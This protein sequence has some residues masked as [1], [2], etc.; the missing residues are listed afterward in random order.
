MPEYQVR[1]VLD[2]KA[3]HGE[4]PLWSVEEQ[5]LF[6]VDIQNK[7]F[8][9]FDPKSGSNRAWTLPATPGCFTFRVGGG[10]VIAANRGYYDFDFATSAI[11]RI[12]AAPFDPEKFRFNDGKADRN[13][14]FWAGS[15]K[16]RF[17]QNAPG[18]GIYYRYEAGVVTP[19]LFDIS[20]PNGTAFSPDGRTMYRAESMQRI[21]YA[22][23]YDPLT[24]V[25][26]KQR[27]FATMPEGFGIPDG[28]AVDTEGGL[29]LAVPFGPTGKI[30]RF[31]PDGR[32][33]VQFDVPVLV[34]TMVSF[35]GP[36]LETLFITSSRM[37]KNLNRPSSPLGGDLFAVETGYRGIPETP[38]A[39]A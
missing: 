30:A 20:V 11:E 19:G 5:A 12:C 33:D 7:S 24:G 39:R 6:W 28:A 2:V 34:P 14:R 29:W 36:G 13:G 15:I 3:D 4:A 37:E 17:D 1:H 35:G 26:S 23:D 32:L 9:R 27:V 21:I 18:E 8:N 22:L 31:T 25:A 16:E 38:I 10:A